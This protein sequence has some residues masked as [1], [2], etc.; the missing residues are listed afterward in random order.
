MIIKSDGNIKGSSTIN[1]TEK[2]IIQDM[3]TATQQDWGPLLQKWL[4]DIYKWLNK[5]RAYVASQNSVIEKLSSSLPE[6]FKLKLSKEFLISKSTFKQL[7]AKSTKSNCFTPSTSK[8]G[9][10]LEI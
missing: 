2:Q 10:M 8:S 5:A 1:E 4:I 6:L 7:D 9:R 3:T